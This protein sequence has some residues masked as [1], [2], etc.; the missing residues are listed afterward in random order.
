M[1]GIMEF[2][3][4]HVTSDDDLTGSM[5]GVECLALQGMYEVNAGNLRRSWRLFRKAITIA[6]LLGLHRV[7]VDPTPNP[8]EVARHH[9]WYQIARGERYLSTL[10]GLPSSTGSAV[11]PFNDDAGW[12]SA[13]DL[14]HKKLL[15]ISGLIL[16]RN[17][18]EGTKA[19]FTTQ[20]IGDQLESLAEQMPPA[21]WEIP[22][23]LLNART[24]E[25][26]I[27]F[28][29]IM[30]QIWHIE[31]ATL[32]HL[33]FMLRAAT[34][35][36]PPA[37]ISPDIVQEQ[38][39]DSRL[40]E[41]VVENFERLPRHGLGESIGTQSISVIRTLQEFLPEGTRSGRLRL[42]IPFFGVIRIARGE[43]V[44]PLQGE[45][46]LGANA[47]RTPA[48]LRSSLAVS[49]PTASISPSRNMASFPESRQ[50]ADGGNEVTSVGNEVRSPD[51]I[52]D[53]SGSSFHLPG[54]SD[55]QDGLGASGWTFQDSEMMFFDSLINTDLVGNWAL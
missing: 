45:R 39:E 6:Q 27:Q 13:E 55:F 42:E 38:H 12:L 51:T 35:L 54:V 22:T 5:E 53:F 33:P 47:C 32:V 2:V 50:N 10:L 25:A 40:V 16:A 29:R 7:T 14:Y 30:C 18:G 31:L 48:F 9:L 24:K 19:F 52:L 3:T 46:I 41:T 49:S 1:S 20:P 36:A 4:Q 44:Q 28:E 17:Q 34:D 26:S 8:I 23:H 15:H 21:W 43:A 37:S 11:F